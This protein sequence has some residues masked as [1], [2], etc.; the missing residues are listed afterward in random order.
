MKIETDFTDLSS[1]FQKQE[2][3]LLNDCASHPSI[4]ST[5]RLDNFNVNSP[6]NLSP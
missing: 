2:R 4:D 5:K 6:F 3:P 1:N